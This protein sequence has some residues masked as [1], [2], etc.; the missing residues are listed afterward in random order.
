M[1]LAAWKDRAIA[2]RN[3]GKDA[4]LREVRSVVA[5]CL[6]RDPRRGRPRDGERAARQPCRR[7]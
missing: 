6:H 2:V 1:N 4:P 5:A 7:G 3:A